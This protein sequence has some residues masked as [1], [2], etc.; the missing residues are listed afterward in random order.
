M[1]DL[2]IT[3]ILTALML[4]W[5]TPRL[6]HITDA[7]L[8]RLH[9]ASCS[10][11]DSVPSRRIIVE[12]PTL[13]VAGHSLVELAS[14]CDSLAR[15]TRGGAPPTE[16]MSTSVNRHNLT[17]SHWKHLLHSDAVTNHFTDCVSTA[18]QDA[19]DNK[20]HD[21]ARCLSLIS[22]AIVDNNLI[23]TALDHASSVLRDN[24]TCRAD[25]L[26]A[27][28]QARLSARMLTALPFILS[29]VAVIIS[30][31]FR[32]SL[33]SP[34]VVVLLMIGL[35]L[36]R[37][38][39]T[40]IS[41]HISTALAEQPPD[42]EL[43]TD[44][45]CVSLRAGLTV[46]QSCERWAGVNRIGTLVAHALRNGDSL[47]HSLKPLAESPD[48]ASRGLVDVVLQAERDGLPVISTINRLSSDAH[49]QRRRLIDIR[50][51][52]LPTRLSIPLV[53]CVL[54]SFLFMSIAPLVLASLSTLTISLPPTTS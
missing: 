27:A 23:P 28:S 41:R 43:L 13:D 15:A 24:A 42:S 32:A 51:R 35:V 48:V 39:W 38:G 16:A 18:L 12:T 54:P 22:L 6:F 45:L 50:I 26:V 20:A 21:D 47:A 5:S 8:A 53:V 14:L 46:S 10:A 31:S 9:I 49:S 44:H 37:A 25:L 40:W 33:T 34:F 7:R 1:I 2:G 19:S 3:V 36:N 4:W 17:G 11:Q 52:Q 29:G 30:A